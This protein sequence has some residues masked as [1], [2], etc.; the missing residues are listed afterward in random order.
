MRYTPGVETADLIRAVRRRRGLTQADAGGWPAGTSQPV[1][2]AY[3][4][5]RRDP[6]YGTLFR[7]CG[8]RRG[9]QV[10]HGSA[11]RTS[12]PPP[13]STATRAAWPTCSP[14]PT[15]SP[16]AAGRPL[17]LHAWCRGEQPT[18]AQRVVALD[19]ALAAVPHA[20][21]GAIAPRTTPS[22]ERRSTSTSTYSSPP[23]APTRSPPRCRRSACR[24]AGTPTL[25]ERDGQVRLWWNDT[26]VDL[27]F[28]YDPFHDTAAKASSSSPSPTERSRSCPPST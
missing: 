3:E 6:T 21:G 16:A 5:G 17:T 12:H 23:S 18:F 26:P 14:W 27:F 20:F 22:R 7:L 19:D 10:R 11:P 28:A 13:T 4:G 1:V 25:I 2:S 8:Q 24:H 15:P 9:G